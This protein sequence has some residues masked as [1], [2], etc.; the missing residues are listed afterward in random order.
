MSS[1]AHGGT[2]GEKAHKPGSCFCSFQLIYVTLN[3]GFVE[4]VNAASI[5]TDN[6]MFCQSHLFE[7]I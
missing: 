3:H 4:S 2:G 7:K 5:S 1:P 6:S